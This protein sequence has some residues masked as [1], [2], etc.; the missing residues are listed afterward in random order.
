MF[1]QLKEYQEKRMKKTFDKKAY[2]KLYYQKNQEKIKKYQRNYH[3]ENKGKTDTLT[4]KEGLMEEL[5]A[6]KKFIGGISYTELIRKWHKDSNAY[7]NIRRKGV[8]ETLEDKQIVKD[9]KEEIYKIMV[10]ASEKTYKTI[11]EANT[12]AYRDILK[13]LDKGIKDEKPEENE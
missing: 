3:K 6:A 2:E 10:T 12:E 5:R 11:Q 4:I 7:I 8:I 1:N 9:F 13:L